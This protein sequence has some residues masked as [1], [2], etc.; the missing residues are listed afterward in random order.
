MNNTNKIIVRYHG[1]KVGEI[2]L[3]ANGL[4]AFEYSP[5]WLADGFSISPFELPLKDGVFIARPQP[6]AGGFGIFDDSLPDGWGMLILDRYLQKNG[7]NLKSLS[8]LDRLALVG[9]TG[10][11]ALEFEPDC[12]IMQNHDFIDF[13]RLS[14][15]AQK[16][17]ASD[18]YNGYG[19]EE[20]QRRGGSPGG[21]RPKIFI[22]SDGTEW[23]VKFKAL[24]DPKNIG[25]TEYRYSLL[26]AK[27]GV[28]MPRTRLFENKYFATERYDRLADG[29]KIHVASV[30]GLLCADYRIPS[31]DYSHI[32]QVGLALTKNISELKKIFRLMS[33]NYL[34][35]NKDDHAKNFSF[36]YNNNK[37]EFAPGYDLLPSDGM[38]GYHSTSI[39]DKITP[40]DDDLITLATKFGLDANESKRTLSEMRALVKS[41]SN[42]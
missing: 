6:F 10:R 9:S 17:L 15:D 26:A 36:I 42:S 18:S 20:F 1:R 37:W 28:E 11:G 12:S 16:I 25:E 22:K 7:I 33:F 27:C 4:C 21:A 14:L 19:I 32:F 38:N 23:L 30:A 3:T 39:N 41:V 31:I 24:H 2:I 8:I 35:G 40:V 29:G 13:S 34:I 5:I